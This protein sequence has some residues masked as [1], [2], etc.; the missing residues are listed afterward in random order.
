[1]C[2]KNRKYDIQLDFFP[3]T[4]WCTK[5]VVSFYLKLKNEFQ[6][7]PTKYQASSWLTCWVGSANQ[8]PGFWWEMA[9]IHF[10]IQ[11]KR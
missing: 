6:A 8:R 2:A 4:T 7:F 11:D 9:G 1:M 5:G 10:S 3:P